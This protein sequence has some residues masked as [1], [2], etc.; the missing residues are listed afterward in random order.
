LKSMNFEEVYV[1]NLIF[2]WEE[3]DNND[4]C[5]CNSIAAQ[6]VEN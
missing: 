6:M 1:F 4:F 2:V 3:I 5:I